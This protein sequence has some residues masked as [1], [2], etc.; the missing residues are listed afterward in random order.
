MSDTEFHIRQEGGGWCVH[1]G[2]ERSVAYLTRKAA[3]EAATTSAMTA[4][5]DGG[6][7]VIRIDAGPADGDAIQG[8]P[9]PG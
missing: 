8:R 7:I 9:A 6:A 2:A 3:L 1:H 5:Y 4:I